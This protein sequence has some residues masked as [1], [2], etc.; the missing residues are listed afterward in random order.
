MT[1]PVDYN[2][3]KEHGLTRY[4]TG[5]PCKR[6]HVAERLVANQTCTK[7]QL[8]R[9]K[10]WLKTP[11]GKSYKSKVDS[12]Y[13]EKY[14]DEKLVRDRQYRR[15]NPDKIRTYWKEWESR[16]PEKV[17]AHIKKQ[18]ARP[19]VK[20]RKKALK[21]KRRAIENSANSENVNFEL[22]WM[23]S[24]GLCYL[25]GGLVDK[26]TEHYDHVIALSQGGSHTYNNVKVTHAKCNLTKSTRTPIAY[27][28]H[29]AILGLANDF[30][31]QA[32]NN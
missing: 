24:A 22:V 18:N 26:G 15:D 29:L 10:L 21:H 1:K 3:A 8:D 14:H 19:E 16:N 20:A 32:L 12:R 9:Q 4:F 11:E 17:A 25:C 13:R 30:Q 7:C 6:G 27:W 5:I 2:Y 28:Q 31:L 23:R